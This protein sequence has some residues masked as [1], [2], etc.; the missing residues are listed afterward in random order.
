[1]LAMTGCGQPRLLAAVVA[2]G[3]DGT[4][5]RV[6]AANHL[7]LVERLTMQFDGP[8]RIGVVREQKLIAGAALHDREGR[9][10]LLRLFRSAILSHSYSDPVGVEV[11]LRWR[12][13]VK[14]RDEL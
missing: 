11:D 2:L 5:D 8:M 7:Q 9:F 4:E 1:M 3:D 12:T 10:A 6:V 14:P 13:W